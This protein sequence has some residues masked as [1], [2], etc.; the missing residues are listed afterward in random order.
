[1]VPCLS[2]WSGTT[3]L[4]VAGYKK[5]TKRGMPPPP[6]IPPLDEDSY[7]RDVVAGLEG[8]HERTSDGE[9]NTCTFF[10][11]MPSTLRFSAAPAAML[12]QPSILASYW[13]ALA[14]CLG[15]LVGYSLAGTGV[16]IS[17]RVPFPLI[18][19]RGRGLDWAIRTPISVVPEFFCRDRRNEITTR[20][21]RGQSLTWPTGRASGSSLF[22]L[23]ARHSSHLCRSFPF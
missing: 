1:M 9:C 12:P 23:W 6:F 11:A 5:L 19:C 21:R 4:L 18:G 8:L 20:G 17:N 15:E 10:S 7:D 2:C 14:W 16:D 22:L 3:P 13:A